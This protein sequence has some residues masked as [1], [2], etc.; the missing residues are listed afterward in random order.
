MDGSRSSS[1][2][3]RSSSSR[4]TRS[5]LAKKADQV[6]VEIFGQSY[7]VRAG[8]DAGYIETLARYVDAQMREVSRGS[9]TVDSLKIAVLA[10]LNIADELHRERASSGSD[11][12]RLSVRAQALVAELDS[13]LDES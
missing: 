3:S 2:N 11:G 6:E 9:T 8:S 10:A 13:V 1:S 5:S 4:Y 7:T 12:E